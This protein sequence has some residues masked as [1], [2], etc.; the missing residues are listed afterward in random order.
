M[1]ER[2]HTTASESAFRSETCQQCSSELGGDTLFV[3]CPRCRAVHHKDCWTNNGGCARHGCAQLS[4][5]ESDRIL[6]PDGPPPGVPRAWVVLGTLFI[7]LAAAVFALQPNLPDPAA[8]RQRIVLL[9]ETSAQEF[10]GL[11]RFADSF[12]SENPGLY[13]ELSSVPYGFM[14]Q[15]LVI[16]IAAGQTPDIF[17]L[18]EE[19]YQQYVGHY[20]LLPLQDAEFE[21]GYQHPS[22][23]RV[24]VVSNQTTDAKAALKTLRGLIDYWET[25]GAAD[26]NSHVH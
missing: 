18:T 16:L 11:E 9:T 26:E 25:K 23:P 12:N 24:V 8:G 14:D 17:T 7:F 4:S 19:R 5:L 3:Q 21:F 13:L 6:K 1:E 20:I 22:Q 15:K 10:A 2:V